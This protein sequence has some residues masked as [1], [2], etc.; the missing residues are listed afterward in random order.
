MSNDRAVVLAD[1][2]MSYLL[3]L[4]ELKFWWVAQVCSISTTAATLVST[5]D[6]SDVI[7]PASSSYLGN[8][9]WDM[10]MSDDGSIAAIHNGASH[11]ALVDVDTQPSLVRFW[12]FGSPFPGSPPIPNPAYRVN[13]S[14]AITRGYTA[15]LTD[16][17]PGLGIHRWIVFLH[18]MATNPTESF[19]H[20]HDLPQHLSG[21][22]A[23]HVLEHSDPGNDTWGVELE[24]NASQTEVLVRNLGLPDEADPAAGG[25]DWYRFN[26]QNPQWNPPFQVGSPFG[27]K[28][29]SIGVDNL[30]QRRG[31]SV[32]ISSDAGLVNKGYV[33]VVRT[34]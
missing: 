8:P 6:D 21:V 31:V 32:S 30:V 19:L 34:F 14:V 13:D 22:Q 23:S 16:G 18:P 33:H 12:G 11:V 26:A 29:Y 5:F 9:P 1:K 17:T 15:P 24:L 25:R 28:G 10:A 7:D 4:C 20:M 2:S 27:G 3:S